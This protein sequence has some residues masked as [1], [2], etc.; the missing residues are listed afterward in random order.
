MCCFTANLAGYEISKC[1]SF[2]VSVEVVDYESLEVWS[3]SG[4][5]VDYDS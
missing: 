5:A 2:S 3:F 4:D 1:W